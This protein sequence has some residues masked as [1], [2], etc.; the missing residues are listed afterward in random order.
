MPLQVILNW[1]VADIMHYGEFFY[2]SYLAGSFE[3]YIG[4]DYKLHLGRWYEG[5][6]FEVQLRMVVPAKK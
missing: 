5:S 3:L 2:H 1:W 4:T 6:M